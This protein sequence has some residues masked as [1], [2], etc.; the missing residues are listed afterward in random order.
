[1]SQNNTPVSASSMDPTGRVMERRAFI[2]T[3]TILG[4]G[5]VAASALPATPASAWPSIY[6]GAGCEVRGKQKDQRD[7]LMMLEHRIGRRLGIM[8]RYSYWDS[9]LPD[10]THLWAAQRGTIPYISLHAYTRTRREIRWSSIAAGDH[11]AAL[12]TKARSLR[13]SGHTMFFSFHHEPEN[14][15]GNGTARDFIAAHDRVRNLFDYEGVTNLVW[16]TTLM[17]S[18]YRGGHGGADLWLPANYDML[19]V[20]GYNRFPCDDYRWRSFREIFGASR[21]RARREAKPLFVGEFGCVE[22]WQCGGP[23]VAMGKADWFK[24]A[25]ETV[26]SWP[27][28]SALVYSHGKSGNGI[29]YWVDSSRP[30]LRAFSRMVGRP[31]YRRTA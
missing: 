31:F 9:P 23:K 5:M 26:R 24:A 19:G 6:V 20:D 15:R 27:Q 14:D 28:V 18:T 29:P 1:V 12:R 8:R 11:D 17:A 16:V 13:D 30:S 21:E 3:S 10:P 22:R 2:R 7:A 25:D 4:A